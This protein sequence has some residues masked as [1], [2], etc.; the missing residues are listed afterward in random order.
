[1]CNVFSLIRKREDMDNKRKTNS[2]HVV[3]IWEIVM[4]IFIH[5]A[6]NP[7]N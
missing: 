1:M 2:Y 3:Y 4:Y 6:V 7:V 5:G